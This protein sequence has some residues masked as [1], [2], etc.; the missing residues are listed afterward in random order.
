MLFVAAKTL[1]NV[2][3]PFYAQGDNKQDRS[4]QKGKIEGSAGGLN[5]LRDSPLRWTSQEPTKVAT[6]SQIADPPGDGEV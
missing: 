5:F 2:P 1:R 6:D 4:M 3:D